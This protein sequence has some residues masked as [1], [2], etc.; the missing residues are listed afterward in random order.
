MLCGLLKFFE[1]MCIRTFPC[2]LLINLDFKLLQ[3]IGIFG[4]HDDKSTK[5]SKR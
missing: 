4:V 1:N 2:T 3:Q 5:T